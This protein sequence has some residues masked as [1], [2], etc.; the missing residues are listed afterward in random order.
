[1]FLSHLEN[2]IKSKHKIVVTTLMVAATLC[3]PTICMAAQEAPTAVVRA[4]VDSASVRMADRVMLRV[5]V[6]KNTSRGVMA[7]LPEYEP[8]K[9]NDF[10]GVE[11]R[12]ITIDSTALPND[13][14]QINYN[15]LLQPF[16]P[17]TITIPAFKYAIDTD[18]FRSEIT[19]LKVLEP[20]MPK[21]MR[22]SLIINPM[23]GTVS[24]KARWYDYV[25]SWWYWVL[26]GLALIALGVTVAILYK[27]NGPSLL[28]HKKVV[29]PHVLALQRL[30]HLKQLHLAESGNDKEYYTELTDILR[31]YLE[32]RFGIFAR[33]MT[34]S[35]ILEAV[36]LNMITAPWHDRFEAML[37]TADF[38]KFAKLRALP[39]ENSSSFNTVRD[40]VEET[41]PVE[42][43]EADQKG[44]NKKQE[45]NPK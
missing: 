19:T 14:M 13:R 24:V 23:M 33:E 5:E 8:G 44:N 17:G 34:S 38:V 37:K 41:R 2:I 40:F 16:N 27:R 29:P 45:N 6:M 42:V 15:I 31:Q 39:Q 21:V 22:D 7:N 4:H 3:I 10:H 28:P 9:K 18:T 25:P 36:D 32:G 35:Q 26:I 30:E 20:D 11:V 43:P 12:D 1:M